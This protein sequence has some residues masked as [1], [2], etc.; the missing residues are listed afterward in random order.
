MNL[1]FGFWAAELDIT[2]ASLV[3]EFE[4]VVPQN[5]WIRLH[6]VNSSDLGKL[7]GR[8]VCACIE[9]KSQTISPPSYHRNSLVLV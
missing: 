1:C 8:H 4:D 3:I 9:S 7:I 5:R 2:H 6:I